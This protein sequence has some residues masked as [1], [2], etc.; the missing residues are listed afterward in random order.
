MNNQTLSAQP[1]LSDWQK[2]QAAMLYHFA[3][4]DYLKGLHRM[5]SDLIDGILDPILA[6]SK[7]QNR[8]SVLIDARW[9]TRN[10]TEN[11]T[12]NA[13]PF[14][15]DLQ[16]SLVKDIAARA[17]ERYGM[18][19]T[20]ECFRGVSEYS[21]QWATVE[22]EEKFNAAVRVVSEYA[23]NIDQTFNDFQFSR[24]TDFDFA[25]AYQKFSAENTRIPQFHIRTDVTAESGKVPVRTGVY[26]AQNDPYASLQFAW[27]GNG[28]GKL[29]LA[30]TFNEI[31]IAALQKVGRKDLWLD[32]EK[33][34]EFA[35]QS[36]QRE[37]FRPTI[38]MLGEEHRTFASGAV[39]EE[40]FI[41][42][43]SKWYFVEMLNDQFESL[44]GIEVEQPPAFVERISGGSVCE[45]PGFYFT[46][47]VAGLRRHFKN[48][49]IAPEHPSQ[50]GKTIWQ[51]D[52]FQ[53]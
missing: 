46:P 40:A 43:H 8:D 50:Y 11:W 6:L 30:N 35:M 28:G 15:K 42:T 48:G 7:S 1:T 10:T 33:M 51:W 32:D 31:G 14:L 9:G 3:S 29:R 12:N 13:W 27:T 49:E 19:G 36:P 38:Y 34:F 16:F 5:V 17:I 44:D 2:K 4:L 45:K 23:I 25:F 47:A 37:L 22:E 20:N 41:N 26:I 21:T 39:A 18:T 53:D 24:W 52:P